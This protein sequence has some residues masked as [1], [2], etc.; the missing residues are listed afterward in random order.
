MAPNR[1]LLW[2]CKE[3]EKFGKPF[4]ILSIL[5]TPHPLDCR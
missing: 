3:G 4:E 2:R 5:H 1:K